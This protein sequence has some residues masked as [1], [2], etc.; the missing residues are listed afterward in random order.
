MSYKIFSIVLILALATLACGFSVSLPKA[1][2]PGPDVTENITVPAP[3]TGATRLNINF[4]AGELNLNPG[5]QDLV[6]GTATYNI[7]DL[8]PEVVTDSNGTEIKQGN[9]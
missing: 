7:P 4:G 6:D 8:K 1:P 5:A 2:T 9:L 3:T